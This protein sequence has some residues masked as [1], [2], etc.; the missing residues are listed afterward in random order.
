MTEVI[1]KNCPK[2]V[3][4]KLYVLREVLQI[5]HVL[6]NFTADICYKCQHKD[7]Q[8]KQFL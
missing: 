8:F 5:A 3:F 1:S 6:I 4:K 7:R 2:H